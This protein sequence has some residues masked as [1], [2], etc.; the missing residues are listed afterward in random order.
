MSKKKQVILGVT[1][2]IAAYKACEIINRL[3]E[4]KINVTVVMTKE[5]SEFIT[6]LILQSLSGNKVV[7]DL[8]ALPDNLNPA[9]ISLAESCDLV[10]IAPASAN[11]V[12]KLA[13]GLADDA[14]SCLCLST[15][16]PI[17]LCCAMNEK[18]FKHKATQE[19]I[20]RLKKRGCRFIGPQRG[21]LICGG[22]GMGHLAAVPEI[23]RETLRLLT[24][25][26][27]SKRQ[28]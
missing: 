21:H 11:V 23:I 27:R 22:E 25:E 12:A 3:R 1:G 4:R 28:P 8:F 24:Q 14:L 20:A 13:A 2:S 9:H 7:C 17:A 26:N 18:M 16:A 15:A 6:P 10:L 5:A 19:N